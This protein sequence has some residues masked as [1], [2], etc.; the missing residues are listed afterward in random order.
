MTDIRV[1]GLKIKQIYDLME[2]QANNR[3]RPL[4]LT[5]SQVIVLCALKAADNKELTLKQLERQ[6]MIQSSTSAGLISRMKDKG[7]V[8]TRGSEDDARITIVSLTAA[9]D[10]ISDVVETDILSTENKLTSLMT[11]KEEE[12]FNTLLGKA[13]DAIK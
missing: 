10:E 1:T 5:I 6:L 4:N 11:K 13:L 12:Q 9:G 7:F 2:K 3:L 8:E